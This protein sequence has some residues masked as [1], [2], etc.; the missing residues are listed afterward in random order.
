M[1]SL[2]LIA[3][4]KRVQRSSTIS[5]MNGARLLT[6]RLEKNGFKAERL[7]RWRLWSAVPSVWSKRS[8]KDQRSYVSTMKKWKWAMLCTAGYGPKAFA[9]LGGLSII[10]PALVKISSWKSGSLKWSSSGLILIT[11]PTSN[12]H[13]PCLVFLLAMSWW[14]ATVFLM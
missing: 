13:P 4:S 10:F 9:S 12:E 1:G 3:S 14:H 11:G 5:W 2:V 7:R 6:E 8:R